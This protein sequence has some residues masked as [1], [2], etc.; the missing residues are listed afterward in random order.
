M[1]FGTTV[2][3]P[4]PQKFL[5][6]DLHDPTKE[7]TK[8]SNLRASRVKEPNA[9]NK[10]PVEIYFLLFQ[11]FTDLPTGLCTEISCIKS[12]PQTCV[13]KALSTL[14]TTPRCSVD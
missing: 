4:M 14:W 13:Y 3:P 5:V 6:T 11:F 9:F 12:Y 7:M 2:L 10:Q 1:L 8:D